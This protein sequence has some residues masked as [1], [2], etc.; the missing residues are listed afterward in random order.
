MEYTKL[1]Q[2]GLKVSVM[3]LGSGGHSRLGLSQG[4][5]EQ[6]AIRVVQAALDLGINYI[7]T[8]EG[9]GS[10]SVVGQG[11]KSVRREDVIISTKKSLSLPSNE[12]RITLTAAE[13]LQGL[14]DSLK[15]LKTDYIDVYSLHALRAGD[16]DYARAEL[17]P[18]L[19][20]ARAQGKIRFIGVT[21]AFNTEPR[22][23]ML[24][25]ALKDDC[26]EVVMVGFNLLNQTARYK[27]FPQTQARQ[28]GVQLM[29]AV[30]K[31]LKNFD[32]LKA[33][34][35]ELTQRGEIEPDQFDP[36]RPLGFLLE[37]GKAAS[38]TEA[39]YRFCR[40]EP[41]VEVVLVGTGNIEHLKANAA[42]LL[43]PPLPEKDVTKLKQLFAK[44]VD[45]TGN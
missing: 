31:A 33:A 26:W 15:K 36:A 7:D 18:A 28:V 20:Q 19:E 14:E 3:G 25:L 23:Q 12:G 45:Y 40:Y 24:E 32:T 2:T 34:L 6:E 10:E 42:S 29:Y 17:V 1:G 16:Y 30:R 39:A 13:L 27:V 44:V 4:H 5:S 8:A 43:K 35:D 9:Y 37:D 21:E 22:H 41:G 38:L 11:I